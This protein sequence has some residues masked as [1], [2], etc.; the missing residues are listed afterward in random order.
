MMLLLVMG[1]SGGLRGQDG[2]YSPV[3]VA[4]SPAAVERMEAAK[5]LIAEE[6]YLDAALTLQPVI[7]TMADKLI[8]QEAGSYHSVATGVEQ[9]IRAQPLL[10][11]AYRQAHAPDAERR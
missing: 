9:L 5:R 6:R 8:A 10:L 7:E 2:A 11:A 3:Y 1:V 4:D